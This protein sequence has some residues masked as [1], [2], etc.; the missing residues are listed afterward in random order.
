MLC[1]SSLKWA[2]PVPRG[3][4]LGPIQFDIFPNHKD[5]ET[6]HTFSRNVDGTKLGGAAGMF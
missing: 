3:S 5:S 4:G 6:E 2:V 1:S